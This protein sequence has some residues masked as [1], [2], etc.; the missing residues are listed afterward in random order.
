MIDFEK[1]NDYTMRYKQRIASGLEP[2]L[3][4]IDNYT[5]PD[6]GA[7]TDLINGKCPNC[8]DFY[9]ARCWAENSV[10]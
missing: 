7:V 5:C 9:L 10:L 4:N 8:F 6:C 1:D 3:E 2:S